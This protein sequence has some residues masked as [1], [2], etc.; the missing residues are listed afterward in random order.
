[1]RQAVKA[2]IG[3]ASATSLARPFTSKWL[4]RRA[5]VIY[6]HRVGPSVP[7]YSA[8]YAGCTISRFRRDLAKLAECFEFVTLAEACSPSKNRSASSKPR[9]ALTFDDGFRLDDALFLEALDDNGIQATAFVITGTIDNADLMWRNKLSTVRALADPQQIATAY[10]AL[11]A[12]HGLDPM[13]SN[14]DL[15]AITRRWPMT[16]KD[17]LADELWSACD[18]EP[19]DSFL[20]REH[21]Y[22]SWE[23][24]D[25]WR[26]LGHEIGLHTKSHPFCSQ[27]GD[28][29]LKQEIVEPAAELRERFDLDVLPFSYPF[30]DRVDERVERELI[31][32][33]VVD[34]LFGIDGLAPLATPAHRLERAGVES[35]GV[36]WPVF[37]QPLVAALRHP[38]RSGLR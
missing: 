35:L 1:M 38:F 13:P 26:E 20:G 17:T 36:T 18:L 25:R 31:G 5:N 12:D 16:E 19:L 22:S 30:G 3:A 15:M 32:D 23:E 9:V 21:P 14:G 4:K 2:A 8:F 37:G 6:Y 11:A 7:Y 28:T 34:Y 33:G 10:N 29:D 24:L 27:L